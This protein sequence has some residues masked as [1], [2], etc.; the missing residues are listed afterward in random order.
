M[1]GSDWVPVAAPIPCWRTSG[2]LYFE[3]EVCETV[4]GV[5]VGFAGANF[6]ADAVGA[7]DKSWAISNDGYPEHR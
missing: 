4:G 2:V 6:Q 3:V 5:K 7:D 1:N